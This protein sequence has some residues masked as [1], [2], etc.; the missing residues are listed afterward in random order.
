MRFRRGTIDGGVINGSARLVRQQ[1]YSTIRN[2]FDGS[3]S[4]PDSVFE[5]ITIVSEILGTI[6]RGFVPDKMTNTI[7]NAFK[8]K[9]QV[10]H[11]PSTEEGPMSIKNNAIV[12]AF[13]PERHGRVRGLAFVPERCYWKHCCLAN[14]FH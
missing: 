11:K 3:T 8:N 6:A 1:Q 5:G 2:W 9:V 14:P 12:H 10:L 7:P 13:G 4:E